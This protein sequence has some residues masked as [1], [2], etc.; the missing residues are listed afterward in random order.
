M[1]TKFAIIFGL[2]LVASTQVFADDQQCV[3][4]LQCGAQG[5]GLAQCAYYNSYTV[6]G[7]NCSTYSVCGLQVPGLAECAYFNTLA[8]CDQCTE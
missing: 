8:V 1:K 2:L 3:V 7:C 6:C 4:G 5:P